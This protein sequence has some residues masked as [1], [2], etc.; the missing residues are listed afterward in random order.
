MKISWLLSDVMTVRQWS[1]LHMYMCSVMRAGSMCISFLFLDTFSCIDEFRQNLQ[2]KCQNDGGVLLFSDGVQ[3]LKV[4]QLQGWRRLCNHQGRLLQRPR[5]AHLPLCCDHL[6]RRNRREENE[7]SSLISQPSGR[8]LY[9]HSYDYSYY[10]ILQ[11]S[12]FLGCDRFLV[13]FVNLL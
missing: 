7:K 8:S 5:C 10:K 9:T 11:N 4:A 12:F 6:K 2:W 1:W 13:L 3:G